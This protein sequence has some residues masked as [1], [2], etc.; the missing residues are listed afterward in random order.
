MLYVEILKKAKAS[1]LTFH[2][3]SLEQHLKKLFPKWEEINVCSMFSIQVAAHEALHSNNLAIAKAALQR[4]H[5]LVSGNQQL[6]PKGRESVILRNLIKV[7]VD[8]ASEK[9][10]P[11]AD[12]LADLFSVAAAQASSQGILD[13]FQDANERQGSARSRFL[14]GRVLLSLHGKGTII[15]LDCDWNWP[16][17]TLH[18]LL[19]KLLILSFQACIEIQNRT[20]PAGCWW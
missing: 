6:F 4:L 20:P 9:G 16:G 11:A 13:F 7:T 19:M 8:A 2:E 14:K 3:L 15:A 18:F 1:H 17:W 12:E 5:G 10:E